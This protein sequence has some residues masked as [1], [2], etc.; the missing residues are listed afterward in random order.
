M[1]EREVFLQT[2]VLVVGG[3]AAGC[4]AA[5]GAMQHTNRVMLVEKGRSI[6][7]SGNL[8]SGVDHFQAILGQEPWDRPENFLQHLVVANE[9]LI[10]LRVA[11][12][13]AEEV[14]QRVLQLEAMGV[15]LREP[16]SGAYRRVAGLGGK[17]R[18]WIN[19]AG[20]NIKPLLARQVRQ[21]SIKVLEHVMVVDLLTDGNRVT[22][23]VGFDTISGD[24]HVFK[25]QAVII[26]TGGAVGHFPGPSGH[27][28]RTH[29]SPFNTGDGYAMGYRAGAELANMEFTYCSVVPRGFSAPGITGFVGLGARIVNARGEEYMTRY[30]PWGNNAPRNALVRGTM[31]EILGGRGPCFIDCSKLPEDA[32]RHVEEGIANEKPLLLEYLRAKGLDLRKDLL[33]FELQEPDQGVTFAAGAGNGM[34]IDR[35]GSTSV[36]GL[37]ACGDCAHVSFAA[38]GAITLGFQAGIAAGRYAAKATGSMLDDQAIRE[39]K[40]RTYAPLAR[41]KGLSYHDCRVQLQGIMEKHV[42]WKRSA[43]ALREAGN[44]LKWCEESWGAVAAGNYHELMRAHEA[45]NLRQVAELLVRASL[46]RQESRLVP[47]HLR[48]DFPERDDAHWLGY[49]ILRRDAGEHK[50]LFRK[51]SQQG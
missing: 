24:F 30:H 11:G 27:T 33:E 9:G 15:P 44:L 17:Q 21:A 4:M 19:F 47:S 14:K 3:G 10:D 18:W 45:E 26:A 32:I 35:D 51:I 37:Y 31:E 38:A 16:E 13:F 25:A 2:D 5:L 39:A 42:G 12:V 48:S 20:G 41:T 6:D 34:V 28:F 23:A 43:G 50:V 22:G 40:W 29:H 46:F 1:K 49:V 8:A 36:E 7:R